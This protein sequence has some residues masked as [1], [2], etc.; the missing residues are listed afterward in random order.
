MCNKRLKNEIVLSFSYRSRGYRHPSLIH[1][2]YSW[3]FDKPLLPVGGPAAWQSGIALDSIRQSTWVTAKKD[4]TSSD[5]YSHQLILNSFLHLDQK[6]ILSCTA[7][8]WR[9][10]QIWSY[11]VTLKV[12]SMIQSWELLSLRHSALTPWIDKNVFSQCNL[13]HSCSCDHFKTCP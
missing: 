4:F 10:V 9:D 11:L 7:K 5:I 3:V 6:L 8:H 1:G 12:H 13:G 2:T